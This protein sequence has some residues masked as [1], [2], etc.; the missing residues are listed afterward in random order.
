ML[1]REIVNT[2]ACYRHNLRIP[3]QEENSWKDHVKAHVVP[4]EE[5]CEIYH[6]LPSTSPRR[7]GRSA[8]SQ[9]PSEMPGIHRHPNRIST[10]RMPSN[11]TNLGVGLGAS[12]LVWGCPSSRMHARHSL[13]SH[14]NFVDL[15]VA[16]MPSHVDSA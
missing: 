1:Q 7:P 2:E 8:N 13:L 12:W 10:I 9:P 15:F 14:R 3:N 11:E 5:A 4:D 16:W 6:R